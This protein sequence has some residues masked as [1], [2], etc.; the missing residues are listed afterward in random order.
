MLQKILSKIKPHLPAQ[1]KEIAEHFSYVFALRVAQQLIG[2]VS[3]FLI[4]RYVPKEIIGHYQFVLSVI[5]LVSITSLPGMRGALMQS[6]ARK[7]G[8]FFKTA[9]LY[10]VFGAFV[11][12][13]ILLM[14]AGY[15]FIINDVMMAFAFTIAALLNPLGQG[16]LIW[17]S[18][19]SGEERFKVLAIIDAM[20]ALIVSAFLML[21]ALFYNESHILL[22]SIALIIPALQNFILWSIEFRKHKTSPAAEDGMKEYG[23]KTSTYHIFPAI[24][25]EVDKLSIYNFMSAADLALYNVASKI[26][27]AAKAVIKDIGS[28]VMPKFARTP[29]YS[30]KLNIYFW[31]FSGVLFVGILFFTFFIFPALF[32]WIVP[33]EYE[34]GLIFGQILLGTIAINVHSILRVNYIMAQKNTASFKAV[35]L[36]SS[37]VKILTAPALIFFFQ[38]WGGIGAIV[39]QRIVNV[40][41]VEIIIHKFHG[42]GKKKL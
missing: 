6:V 30:Q 32:Q 11:G 13:L 42:H 23:L 7:R 34:E 9:T 15:H 21:S 17:K 28:V 19:Y 22:L 8:G 3:F 10:S 40:V 12:S 2:F 38:L 4:V 27:N 36:L 5:A 37:I 26:P 24:A 33:P 29:H 25:Q 14:I 35:T 16:L 31:L 20:T 41:G 1:Y 39:L 18:S